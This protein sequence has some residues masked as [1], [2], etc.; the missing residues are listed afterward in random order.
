MNRAFPMDGPGGISL[1]LVGAR[2]QDQSLVEF[3]LLICL[4]NNH[5]THDLGRGKS[6]QSPSRE[7]SGFT[8]TGTASRV[9]DRDGAGEGMTE[10]RKSSASIESTAE[11]CFRCSARRAWSSSLGSDP[12]SWVVSFRAEGPE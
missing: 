3:L 9:C 12:D 1:A 2:G 11:V 7:T 10:E 4:I 5:L 8:R 6:S